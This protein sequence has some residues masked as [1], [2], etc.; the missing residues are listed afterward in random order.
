VGVEGIPS[1]SLPIPTHSTPPT[2]A[3]CSICSIT[4]FKSVLSFPSTIFVNNQISAWLRI[5]GLS[6]F[7]SIFS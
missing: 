5:S 6:S 7:P 3:I 2:S 1:K 4:A